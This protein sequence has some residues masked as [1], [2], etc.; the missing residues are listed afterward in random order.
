M[1]RLILGLGTGHTDSSAALIDDSGIVAAIAEERINRIKHAAG[2]PKSAIRECLRIA[3]ADPK[4]IT[5]IAVARDPR[6]NLGAKVSFVLRNPSVGIPRVVNRF[7]FHQ[8][9]TQ[10]TPDQVGAAVGLGPGE[11]KAAFHHVEHHVAHCASSF[12]Q[13]GFERATGLT[14]DGAGDFASTMIAVCEGNDIRPVRKDYWPNSLG[15]FYTG[16]CQFVGFNKFGEEF[17]VMGLSAYGDPERYKSEMRKLVTFQP[18]RGVRLNFRYFQNHRFR[19]EEALG[20]LEEE[21][22]VPGQIYAPAMAELFGGPARDRRN[23]LTQRENDIAASMQR[24]FEEIY[25]RIVEEAVATTGIRDI[26]MAGGVCLNGVGNGRMIMEGLVD[27]AYFHPACADDGTAAGAALHVLH[28]VHRAPRTPKNEYAYFG[29]EWTDEQIEPAVKASGYAYKKLSREELLETAT[30]A[31]CRGKIMGWFQ[32]RE[33]WGPRALGNRSILCHPGWPDMK[34]TLNA[35]IKNR[36]P[37][38][39]FAPAV[40]ADRCGDV[41]THDHEV[42]F[43]VVVYFVKPEWRERLSAITHE[44]GTG[45]VQTVT[46]ENNE[47]YYDLIK[48]FDSRTGIPVLLNTSFNENEPVVHR[49]EE[50]VA[51]F[52]R[53]K[54]DVLC[55]GSYFLEKPEG[56]AE[57]TETAAAQAAT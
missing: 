46:R 55:I 19:A 32:G 56:H 26:C 51:C 53:T 31:L 10:Q 6:A 13:S 11:F 33:E 12:Y 2:F 23:P 35:R 1:S 24:H 41:F 50:A 3:G 42:P 5:D 28:A 8:A 44:D 9:V 36:E 38:R 18:G 17:K 37:F 22:I 21:E 39:P 47:L 15:A 40:L 54:M 14:V 52:D 7:R 48:R 45:R 34:A 27:R 57:Q 20:M 16:I 29:P 30:D 25:L 43:M 4:D 49:P